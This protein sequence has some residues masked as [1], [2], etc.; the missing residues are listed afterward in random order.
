[1]GVKKVFMHV[2]E[3]THVNQLPDKFLLQICSIICKEHE[4]INLFAKSKADSVLEARGSDEI[5]ICVS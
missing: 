3:I 4:S 2:G 5:F 1:V